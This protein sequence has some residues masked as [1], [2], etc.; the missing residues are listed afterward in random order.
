MDQLLAATNI[1]VDRAAKIKKAL[2]GKF[3]SNPSPSEGLLARLKLQLEKYREIS[4]II[5]RDCLKIAAQSA[6]ASDDKEAKKIYDFAIDTPFETSASY[7]ELLEKF[8]N[9]RVK[10]EGKSASSSNGVER[11]QS[12]TNIELK[13]RDIQVP[14]FHGEARKFPEF[15][16]SFETLVHNN[17]LLSEYEKIAHLKGALK[18]GAEKII[19]DATANNVS[20]PEAWAMVC[21][22]F[23]NKS[24]ILNCLFNDL[25]TIQK[26]KDQTQ[27]RSLVME[28]DSLLRG[29]KTAGQDT[30]TWGNWLYY[31]VSLK[32]DETTHQDWLNSRSGSDSY[33]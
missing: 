18:N 14:E 6:Q 5:E 22:W 9:L 27:L 3:Q 15:R 31:F 24:M 11:N 13:L 17:S 4:D 28:V 10:Y 25:F 12:G 21:S 29:L 8:E 32:L 26:L 2:S 16:S 19:S 7:A 33:I 20:Y 30:S 23:E 1:N